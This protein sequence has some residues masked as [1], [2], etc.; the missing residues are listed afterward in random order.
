M[1][2]LITAKMEILFIIRMII[3]IV[4]FLIILHQIETIIILFKWKNQIGLKII[5]LILIQLNLIVN[6]FFY[7]RGYIILHLKLIKF[8]LVIAKLRKLDLL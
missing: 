5:D 7:L 6:L 1:L 3:I 4:H 2:L 8:L